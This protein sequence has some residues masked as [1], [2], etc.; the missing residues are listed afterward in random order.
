MIEELQRTLLSLSRENK[1]LNEQN[2][3]LRRQLFDMASKVRFC[4]FVSF[5]R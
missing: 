3:L 2:E 1:E 5:I 4:L